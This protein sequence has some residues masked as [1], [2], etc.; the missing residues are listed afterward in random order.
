MCVN[1]KF[2]MPLFQGWLWLKLADGSAL[3]VPNRSSYQLNFFVFAFVKKIIDVIN[4][5]LSGR[6]FFSFAPSSNS[7]FLV[8]DALK[9]FSADM[10]PFKGSR[11]ALCVASGTTEIQGHR[12]VCRARRRGPRTPSTTTDANLDC[13]FV[14]N[15]LFYINP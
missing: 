4:D 14:E 6:T 15:A 10:T 8:S 11:F 12:Q 9:A 3:P 13:A 7:L 1:F 2:L 5:P